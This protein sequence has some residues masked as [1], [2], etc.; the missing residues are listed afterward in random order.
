LSPFSAGSALFAAEARFSRFLEKS[1]LKHDFL[2]KNEKNTI[3]E[4]ID[5]F[6]YFVRVLRRVAL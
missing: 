6:P 3:S 1:A 5:L 4:E 2:L